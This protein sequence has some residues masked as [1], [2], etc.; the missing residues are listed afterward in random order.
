MFFYFECYLYVVCVLPL[1]ESGDPT[2]VS[3]PKV[4]LEEEEPREEEV[5]R[6]A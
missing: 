6:N 3:E 4:R 2:V 5:E 1:E